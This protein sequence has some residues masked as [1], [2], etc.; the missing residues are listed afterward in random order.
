MAVREVVVSGAAPLPHAAVI[1]IVTRV[2]EREGREAV[3]SVRFVGRDRMRHLHRRFKGKSRVTDVLGFPLA[4]PGRV[5]VGD[6]YI[7]PWVARRES[8]RHGIPAREEVARYVIHGVLHVLGHEH[9]EGE[10]R[11][12]SPMWK[13]QERYVAALT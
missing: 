8:R 4:G 13:R 9:P 6:L 7:C 12:R 10:E 2:L 1:R 3:I 11:T 5:V